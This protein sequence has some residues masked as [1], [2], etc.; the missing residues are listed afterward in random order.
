[1]TM[2]YS[3]LVGLHQ[4]HHGNTHLGASIRM[5]S[6]SLNCGL[7]AN[8]SSTIPWAQVPN[9]IKRKLSW[10]SA[11]ISLILYCGAMISYPH[12][13]QQAFYS[14]MA[15]I[16]KLQ[17][18]TTILRAVLVRYFTTETR[19]ATETHGVLESKWWTKWTCDW[20]WQIVPKCHSCHSAL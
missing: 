17:A 2:L 9:Q 8:M 10:A 20:D 3:V 6:E 15:H 1:M 18:K 16:L 5:S 13:G 19:K 11:L 12:I 14:A 4:N 7:N